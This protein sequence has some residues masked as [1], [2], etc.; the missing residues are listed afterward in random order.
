MGM[1]RILRISLV[2]ILHLFVYVL[3]GVTVHYDFPFPSEHLA[4]S[5]L[6]HTEVVSLI[7]RLTSISLQLISVISQNTRAFF[8]RNKCHTTVCSVFA[9]D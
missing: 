9:K 5:P 6:V 2:T 7:Q 1:Y 3:F 8:V 4:R